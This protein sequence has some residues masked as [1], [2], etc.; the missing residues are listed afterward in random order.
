MTSSLALYGVILNTESFHA[1]AVSN[2]VKENHNHDQTRPPKREFV[3]FTG[4]KAPDPVVRVP[5][6]PALS[7]GGK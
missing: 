2:H 3:T 7:Q 6:Y 1:L 4:G 5:A